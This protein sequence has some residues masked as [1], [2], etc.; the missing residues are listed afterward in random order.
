MRLLYLY[1]RL[2]IFH[3]PLLFAAFLVLLEKVD[4]SISA[5][6]GTLN[7]VK[8]EVVLKSEVSV[9]HQLEPEWAEF[10]QEEERDV[11]GILGHSSNS[12]SICDA[13]EKVAGES[14]PFYCAIKPDLEQC[15]KPICPAECEAGG[16]EDNIKLPAP[17]PS[18][19]Y[20]VN[21]PK[22]EANLLPPL[23]FIPPKGASRQ[24][25]SGNGGDLDPMGRSLDDQPQDE[26]PISNIPKVLDK[27]SLAELRNLL[28]EL[29]MPELAR[30]LKRIPEINIS[31]DNHQL[32]IE[33][34]IPDYLDSLKR[35]EML[36][37][38]YTMP[39]EDI[40]K[41]MSKLALAETPNVIDALPPSEINIVLRG[42]PIFEF[43]RML[44][45]L[46]LADIRKVIKR[47]PL[48]HIKSV[49]SKLPLPEISENNNSLPS[50]SEIPKLLDKLHLMDI[51]EVLNSVPLPVI[52][53]VIQEMDVD[54]LRKFLHAL[55][56]HH[57]KNVLQQLPP[58]HISAV[59]TK[60]DAEKEAGTTIQGRFLGKLKLPSKKEKE[61][62]E[63]GILGGS[64]KNR[65]SPPL[66]PT[67]TPFSGISGR[68]L[69]GATPRVGA[70]QPYNPET[71]ELYSPNLVRIKPGSKY[72]EYRPDNP[73][74][75]IRDIY[76]TAEQF[77]LALA[78][79]R[80]PTEW[81][82]VTKTAILKTVSTYKLTEK[83]P[84]IFYAI[85][86]DDDTPKQHGNFLYPTDNSSLTFHVLNPA[87]YG[88]TDERCAVITS[89]LGD[90]KKHY[91][92]TRFWD[93]DKNFED[94]KKVVYGLFMY[95]PGSI[96]ARRSVEECT[97]LKNHKSGKQFHNLIE[98]GQTRKRFIYFF[99]DQRSWFDAQAL[100]KSKGLSF[101]DLDPLWDDA[102]TVI[103][104]ID[105]FLKATKLSPSTMFWT[106]GR[107]D[108]VGY[109]DRRFRW[110]TTKT[111]IW[112]V[113]QKEPPPYPYSFWDSQP[114]NSK[115]PSSNPA[116][117]LIR[118]ST[119]DKPCVSIALNPETGGERPKLNFKVWYCNFPMFPLC[120]KKIE[121]KAKLDAP[122]PST[123]IGNRPT[124][125]G[126]SCEKPPTAPPPPPP[127]PPTTTTTTTTTTPPPE[128]A[129]TTTEPTT[130]TTTTT[131]APYFLPVNPETCKSESLLVR[132][133]SPDSK[134]VAYEPTNSSFSIDQIK[135]HCI[136]FGLVPAEVRSP[137]DWDSIRKSGIDGVI[138]G[139]PGD[140]TDQF[141]AIGM[142]DSEEAG[143]IRYNS[144]DGELLFS[145]FNPEGRTY[146]DSRC[147]IVDTVIAPDGSKGL[148]MLH[149][150]CNKGLMSAEKFAYGLCMFP[151]DSKCYRESKE[152]KAA[153][154]DPNLLT[155]IIDIGVTKT[156]SIFFPPH[157]RS[158]EGA[159][160]YCEHAKLQLLDFDPKWD[161]TEEIIKIF[162]SKIVR[163]LDQFQL[164]PI[165]TSGKLEGK[166]KN[167]K[168]TWTT[169]GKA[170]DFS[171]G[172]SGS[173]F[174]WRSLDDPELDKIREGSITNPC[175]EVS[176]N[177]VQSQV[178]LRPDYCY[179]PKYFLC[180]RKS[181]RRSN[182]PPPENTLGIS[183]IELD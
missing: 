111:F 152:E 42:L 64:P 8:T 85:G 21:L 145:M 149:D 140:T 100:C 123:T 73:K 39:M 60:A 9:P 57:I 131:P 167:K 109:S 45:E 94:P 76:N 151:R 70:P 13:C 19:P 68:A 137:D 38:F 75:Q 125:A 36:K 33:S 170:L 91:L 44:E 88:R 11:R 15:H 183:I 158:W 54:D 77:G 29:P 7:E 62:E 28:N 119:I 90:D 98:M 115:Q 41:L 178:M 59:E 107:Y 103:E 66:K 22:I 6:G 166:Y 99:S 43:R 35:P 93:C 105:R 82:S 34:E 136:K 102:L 146:L 161:D 86:A 24:D 135:S 113:Y 10:E 134:Y 95:P 133:L 4:C 47:I 173:N 30:V 164:T 96:C 116:S 141:Y 148:M 61:W 155:T 129:T 25:K 55:P 163:E 168:G 48:S 92:T 171:S 67:N 72:I 83:E 56:V 154:R 104:I 71:C 5:T 18:P 121:T 139:D 138:Q 165:W 150:N 156:R 132:V 147:S 118:R 159:K 32:P 14:V 58:L 65:M 160:E 31:R 172:G 143:K 74:L 130:T 120:H 23:P 17:R 114:G 69:V 53:K 126:D 153:A 106:A 63:L 1:S 84:R 157:Q 175:V 52:L 180:W 101:L 12:Q 112:N 78:E 124:P 27:L 177:D 117:D 87:V 46:E 3:I 20:P 110:D 50:P 179:I 2:P 37:V 169:G 40:R 181:K 49:L 81:H 142:D 127:P 26:L 122:T 16:G 162:T 89:V 144:D 174:Q 182:D 80:Y 108:Y 79:F 97:M 51:R 128:V 176:F